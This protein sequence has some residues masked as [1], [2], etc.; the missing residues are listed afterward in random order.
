MDVEFL[1]SAGIELF[2]SRTGKAPN[3]WQTAVLRGTLENKTYSQIAEGRGCTGDDYAKGVGKKLFDLFSIVLEIKVTKTNFRNALEQYLCANR[4][5]HTRPVSS[6]KSTQK[7]SVTDLCD[8][9][10]NLPYF[11]ELES[12]IAEL[13]AKANEGQKI[14]LIQA[15]GGVGKTTLAGQYFKTQNFDIVLNLWMSKERQNISSVESIVKDWLQRYFDEEPGR[16]F[17][18]SLERLRR[19]LEDRSKKIGVFIDNL[20]PAL[21][22]GRFIENRGSYVELLRMLSH[23]NVQSLTIITSREPI[24]E[25]GISVWDYRLKELSKQAWNEFFIHY[26]INTGEF[27][28]DENSVLSS[29]HKAYGGNA[30]A[31]FVFNGDI[32]SECQGDL[33]AYWE[34]NKDDLLS[35]PTLE[36]LIKG[37]FKKLQQDEPLAYKLLCRLGCYRYQDIPLVSKEGILCLLWDVPEERRKRLIKSLCNRSLVKRS[38]QEFYIHPVIKAEA[39]NRLKE[40]QDWETTNRKIAEFWTESV[41]TIET[42]EHAL[43]A[44]EAYY[45]YLEINDLESCGMVCIKCRIN[46]WGAVNEALGVSFCRLG[47]LQ[48]MIDAIDRVINNIEHK[49][50][51]SRLNNIIGDLYW[52]SGSLQT[53]INCHEL[54]EVISDEALEYNEDIEEIFTINNM[55]GLKELKINSFFNRGLCHLDLWNIQEA[56]FCFTECEKYASKL[57]NNFPELYSLVPCC[58][59]AFAY[60]YLND[61]TQTNDFIKK[62]EEKIEISPNTLWGTGHCMFFLGMA[63]KNLG[64]IDKSFEM[65]NQAISF[66]ENV[67]YSQLQA[68]ISTGLAELYR[69]ENKFDLAFKYHSKSIELLDK[70]CAK[71]DLAEAYFQQALSYEKV[72]NIKISE[73][74]RDMAIQLFSQIKAPKQVEKVKQAM[75]IESD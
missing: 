70:L 73:E 20:E 2:T 32:I 5:I 26:G 71:C 51:R 1:L 25:E 35:N 63:H 7:A 28:L 40:S 33:E 37:Q 13:N 30:E 15:E 12:A 48:P 69:E 21:E 61:F 60:S 9:D 75:L 39:I 53:A 27:P 16:E 54:S 46:K 31:M 6:N 3:D 19:K 68:K 38:N 66:T 49:Y 23:P 14:I 11:V 57:V 72:G 43:R 67:Y 56:I 47:L 50:L 34:E 45:H 44:F 22:N 10:D 64:N 62:A 59:L 24:H 29:M 18:I 74:N 52:E 4:F 42:V 36:N 58:G 17:G 41:E 8:Y 55:I 65:Y